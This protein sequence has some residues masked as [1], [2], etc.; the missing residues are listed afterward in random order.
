MK[1]RQEPHQEPESLSDISAEVHGEVHGDLL[2][3]PNTQGN[4]DGGQALHSSNRLCSSLQLQ[5][6]KGL[7]NTLE[8]AI[9]VKRICFCCKAQFPQKG[10]RDDAMSRAEWRQPVSPRENFSESVG[11]KICRWSGVRKLQ[12]FPSLLPAPPDQPRTSLP[13]Q[14]HK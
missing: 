9:L 1:L 3:G 4:R 2:L 7:G 12:A 8:I 11:L 14:I 10:P 13:E 6:I 5:E